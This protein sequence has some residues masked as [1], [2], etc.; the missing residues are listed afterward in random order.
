MFNNVGELM[1]NINY[2]KYIYFFLYTIFIIY[3]IEVISQVII[4]Q[5]DEFKIVVIPVT[6]L[7]AHIQMAI[8][9]HE[10]YSLLYIIFGYIY[11][12]FNNQVSIA[13]FII[14]IIAATIY[15]AAYYLSI[16][17]QIKSI[18]I[19]IIFAI[20]VYIETAIYIPALNE[21]RHLGL[22]ASG[23]WHNSSL[24]AM[25]LM[26]VIFLIQ[27]SY[28]LNKLNNNISLTLSDYLLFT[29]TAFIST[30][31]KPNLTFVIYPALGIM[32]LILFLKN[33]KL[34]KQLVLLLCTSIPLVIILIVQAKIMYPTGN[35]NESIAF[36]PFYIINIYYNA[37]HLPMFA[38]FL[39]VMF[40]SFLFPLA[41]LPLLYKHLKETS[42]YL[43]VWISSIIAVTE[44]IVLVE[45]G[46]RK[47]HGNWTWG[48]LAATF[49]LF[50]VTL[51]YL[52][53]IT[54]E[55]WKNGN[56]VKKFILIFAYIALL[57]HAVYGFIYM[58]LILNSVIY[59]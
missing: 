7:R 59:S 50:L 47:H 15:L 11:K 37:H 9:G 33:R 32:A 55:I 49:L 2:K 38:A 46:W 53:R 8:S 28:L 13:V 57:V 20:L 21:N 27:I 4:Y 56:F 5:I 23:V 48:A 1:N 43:F 24:I 54:P 51:E 39:G 3:C 35:T 26:A 17:T 18:Y 40:Q 41:A 16:K 30:W 25:K 45:T 6:D 10:R 52:I 44:A 31:V 58:H 12:I 42:M 34:L 14:I 19:C 29:L 36:E 22:F